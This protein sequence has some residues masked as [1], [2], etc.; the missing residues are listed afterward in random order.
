MI[1]NRWRQ[2]IGSVIALLLAAFLL[3]SSATGSRRA[4]DS[5]LAILSIRF[6]GATVYA[7]YRICDDSYKNLTVLARDSRPGVAPQTRRFTTLVAPKPCLCPLQAHGCGS[8]YTRHWVLA[9]RFRG[10]G[11][12]TG[13]LRATDKSGL[14]SPP[15]SR[16]FTR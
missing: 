10:H 8:A 2:A 7:R 3:T 4:A 13:T 14:T 11:N 15:A 5:T 9:P 16:T 1:R 6:T 12:Y